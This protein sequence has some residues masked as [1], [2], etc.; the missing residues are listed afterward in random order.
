MW[1]PSEDHPLRRTFAGLAEHAFFSRVGIAD[2][3][4]TDYISTLLA[5]FVHF[6]DIYRLRGS[7]G[8]PLTELVEMVLEAEQLP[9]GRTRRE[10]YRH[11]GDFALFWT[12]VYPE[13]ID[14]IH[15]RH[16]KDHF[17]DYTVQGKRGYWITS[18]MDEEDHRDEAELF[19]RLSERFELCAL[20]LREV[21]REWESHAG[22]PPGTGIGD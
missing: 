16:R 8:R 5:R 9:E 17:I 1:K 21:R 22:S 6:D 19:R 12:G 7:D 20:G 13:A 15:T 2:P 14:R 10:Y 3:V 11:I 4:L 18:Q